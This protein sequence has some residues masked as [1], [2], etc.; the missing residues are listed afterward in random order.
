QAGSAAK[1][2]G[3]PFPQRRCAPSP[4]LLRGE[5]WGEGPSPQTR[6]ADSPP[7]PKPSAST[8]PR[9]RGEV[10]QTSAP[11][12]LHEISR[13]RNGSALPRPALR[14]E[15]VRGRRAPH[16]PDSRILPPPPPPPCADAD[17]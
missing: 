16:R 13:L 10:S 8:S 6:L 12:Q 7:H 3:R 2:H 11:I 9:K 15:T 1:R 5:G 14:G 17:R 4:P